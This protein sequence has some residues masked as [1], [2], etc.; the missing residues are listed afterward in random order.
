M[1][2]TQL[3]ELLR[4]QAPVLLEQGAMYLNFCRQEYSL[5]WNLNIILMTQMIH[6]VRWMNKSTNYNQ[7]PYLSLWLELYDTN[8]NNNKKIK[9][10]IHIIWFHVY[11]NTY[12]FGFNFYVL[13]SNFVIMEKLNMNSNYS[14]VLILQI[15][16]RDNS[17]HWGISLWNWS[18]D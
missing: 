16:N 4:L 12:L 2:V 1:T 3:W 11:H 18:L 9:I 13:I 17:L 10:Y 8:L 5:V 6:D 14:I 7:C 15:E